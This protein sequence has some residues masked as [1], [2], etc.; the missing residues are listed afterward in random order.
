MAA[1]RNARSSKVLSREAAKRSSI[2]RKG[3]MAQRCRDCGEAALI[4]SAAPRTA[5]P[6]QSGCAASTRS[7]RS[8]RALR[9]E[10]FP[11]SRLRVS[12]THRNPRRRTRDNAREFAARKSQCGRARP[13]RGFARSH[14]GVGLARSLLLRPGASR[15]LHRLGPAAARRRRCGHASFPPCRR[16]IPRSSGQPASDPA[17][18]APV[19]RSR[20]GPPGAPAVKRGGRG[21]L[22]PLPHPSRVGS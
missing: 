8:L 1:A 16:G 21:E 3:T 19:M 11:P 22:E 7:L 17:L 13:V 12:Q 20:P 15:L 9:E 10:P 5:V 14:T 2:S 6:V 4:T 18:R